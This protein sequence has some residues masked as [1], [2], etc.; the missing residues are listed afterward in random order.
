MAHKLFDEVK[1]AS[2]CRE[3]IRR[4]WP[5]HF[6]EVGNIKC[7]FHGDSG[8]SMSIKK[9]F[10]VCHGACQKSWSAIDLYQ[11]H[12]GKTGCSK[13]EL[14]EL[15][16]EM[17]RE[18]GFP[19]YDKTPTPGHAASRTSSPPTS[20][21]LKNRWTKFWET[22]LS[23]KAREYL[24]KER[25]IPRDIIDELNKNYLIGFQPS[26][27][28]HGAIEFPVLDWHKKTLLS[29]Q[30]V[31]VGGGDKKF[32]KGASPKDGFFKHGNGGDYCV[33]SE[34]VIDSLS[35][36][37]ACRSQIFLDSVSI[38]SSG[39]FQKVK[40][41]PGS[42]PIFF[43]DDDPSGITNTV[44]A[45]R[46]LGPGRGKSVDWSLAEK[47]SGSGGEDGATYRRAA[48]DT[49]DLWK[50]G[51]GD[52]ILRMVKGAT[53]S[54]DEDGLKARLLSLVDRARQKIL[55]KEYKKE[56]DRDK[57]LI[58]LDRLEAEVKAPPTEKAKK[59]PSQREEAI[60]ITKK[61]G[62]Y[63]KTEYTAT[64]PAPKKISNFTLS[65]LRNFSS[66]SGMTRLIKITH[67][68]GF[69]AESEVSSTIM[70]SRQT[71]AAWILGQ[72]NFLFK[73]TQA[74]LEKMWE[75]EL[76]A[77]DGKIIYRP[78]HIGWVPRQGL[79]LFGDCAVK[80]GDVF[81]PDTD[82]IYWVDESGYQPMAIDLS[83]TKE[84]IC[85]SVPSLEWRVSA[86]VSEKARKGI[87]EKLK[88]NLG[89]FEA[90]LALGFVAGCAYLDEIFR[91]YK[92]PILFIFGRRQCG[93]N[94]L[95]NTLMSH[96]GL[97]E[98]SS[99]NVV[100][101]TKA[102]LSRKLAY[103]SNIPVWV[104]EYRSGDPK[105]QEKDSLLRSAYDRVGGSKGTLGPGV[106]SPKVRAPLI[107]T[108]EGFPSDSA[109]T[110]RCAMIQLSEIRRK[111]D[112][113]SDIR[114]YMPNLSAVFLSFLRS[115]TPGK[116]KKLLEQIEKS[117]K[118]LEGKGMDPR[119]SSVYATLSTSFLQ[120]YY[121]EIDRGE[122]E[123]FRDWI[124]KEAHVM[125]AEKEEKL[126][127]HEFLYDMEVLRARG[128]LNGSHVEIER[129][130]VDGYMT[131]SLVFI[132]LKAVYNIWAE[133]RKRR[134][135]SVWSYQDLQKYF[136]EE[137]YF[138]EDSK[139]KK[140][141]LIPRR[142]LVFA[143]DKIPIDIQEVFNAGWKNKEKTS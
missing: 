44:R 121:P 38:Y 51:K 88:Q 77:N 89:G 58:V 79:W 98:W 106:L 142:S 16:K 86:E 57:D 26:F 45:L 40:L 60:S 93:K 18:L 69:S 68:N 135:E 42:V 139:L 53:G 15:V 22:P 67:E 46:M 13:K 116:A 29:I 109:L 84:E 50:A 3:L 27:G 78:D 118:W 76:D 49:N 129:K 114:D 101:I 66:P 119:L 24:E 124:L 140:I 25:G 137:P 95:A 107:V 5:D 71:F 117:K 74:D 97:G 126:L 59:D 75:L 20:A 100:S 14:M 110:S 30:H 130:V 127:T 19:D 31:P 17:A 65:I 72:G 64:G 37:A 11:E 103:Y 122:A 131:P 33:I 104:D 21:T 32:V 2:D 28:E 48:K 56:D 43:L 94:T 55:H 85:S 80:D 63:W 120:T 10:A 132:W 91:E 4:F 54:R 1:A 83:E 99:D 123:L 125:K 113:Y 133:D 96:W 136:R 39:T 115:K 47:D 90:Y 108:G 92:F 41:I 34:A 141:N 36:Y 70:V 9:E 62:A 81:E 87:V 111:D 102:A 35:I 105:C 128:I 134:G 73:G 61:D 138:V 8:P 52:V 143:W 23:E 82:G 12:H 112:L 6:K 7:P